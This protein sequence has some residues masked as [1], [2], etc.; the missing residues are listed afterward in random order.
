MILAHNGKL[1]CE[2]SDTCDRVLFLPTLMRYRRSPARISEETR[3][4]RSRATTLVLETVAASLP[5]VAVDE[6][7]STRTTIRTI[8][9]WDTLR[10]TSSAMALAKAVVCH[11]LSSPSL[12]TCNTPTRHSR[13]EALRWFRPCRTHQTCLLRTCSPTC[14]CR[15][16]LNIIIRPRWRRSTNKYGSPPPFPFQ[17]N[18]FRNRKRKIRAVVSINGHFRRDLKQKLL[19]NCVM[20]TSAHPLAGATSTRMSHVKTMTQATHEWFLLAL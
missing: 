13:P 11:R 20:V 18:P 9:R 14:L 12:A 7:T 3:A 6:E 4:T 10:T 5:R 17:V 15:H 16:R 8:T 19:V 1:T 2:Y